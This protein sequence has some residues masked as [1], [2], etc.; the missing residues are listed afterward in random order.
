MGLEFKTCMYANRI[1]LPSMDIVLCQKKA[2]KRCSRISFLG[3]REMCIAT[4]IY[5][6]PKIFFPK[7][8][9]DEDRMY[10]CSQREE[11]VF[12]PINIS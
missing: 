3:K 5:Y 4:K 8:S 2:G 10:Q 7:F 11:Y 6:K 12:K 1:T 9:V